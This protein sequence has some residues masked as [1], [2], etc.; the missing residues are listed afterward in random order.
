[1][2]FQREGKGGEGEKE[3]RSAEET[4]KPAGWGKRKH[5][6]MPVYRVTSN[7]CGIL[8]H[9]GNVKRGKK[10]VEGT[11]GGAFMSRYVNNFA[12]RRTGL[13]EERQL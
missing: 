8:R 9:T 11:H 5:F 10:R 12:R 6:T 7:L 1:M 3:K 4:K 13:R 2:L